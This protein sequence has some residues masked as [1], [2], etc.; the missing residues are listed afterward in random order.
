M[1]LC[2]FPPRRPSWCWRWRY[3]RLRWHSSWGL[4]ALL[5]TQRNRTH[6]ITVSA[7]LSA[8]ACCSALQ[9]ADL[10]VCM[11]H[12]AAAVLGAWRSR[13]HW[14][15]PQ[16]PLPTLT[17]GHWSPNYCSTLTIQHYSLHPLWRALSL[18]INCIA[19]KEILTSKKTFFW[20]VFSSHSMLQ[21][22]T[23]CQAL[24][25]RM[26]ICR[27]FARFNVICLQF[28]SRALHCRWPGRVWR[29]VVLML[30]LYQKSSV[31]LGSALYQF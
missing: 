5:V 27:L 29:A 8:L 6:H 24:E 19:L 18:H 2:Q 30:D 3:R 4:A 25:L 13:D 9:S 21:R 26:T 28:T 7:V 20:I 15:R 12:H 17:L 31:T 22:R 1:L 16:L 11:Q 10:Q 14:W 23:Q